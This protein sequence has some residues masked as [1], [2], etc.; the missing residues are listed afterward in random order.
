MMDENLDVRRWAQSIALKCKITPI[1]LDSFT[2]PFKAILELVSDAF[3]AKTS[4]SLLNTT[5]SAPYAFAQ[6]SAS[7]W[8]GFLAVL[9]LVPVE[10]LTSNAS[11]KVDLRRIV[12]GHLH[13]IG[14]GW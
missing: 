2:S 7:L 13:N 6:D 4:E 3:T 8:A 9:R 10:L 14:S 12:I 5:A 1:P 11:V